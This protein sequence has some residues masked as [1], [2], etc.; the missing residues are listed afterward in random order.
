MLFV[1][2]LVF[3]LAPPVAD[4]AALVEPVGAL[5]GAAGHIIETAVAV[6]GIVLTFATQHAMGRSWR[7]GVDADERTELVT[8]GAFAIVR[9]PFFAALLP[10]SIG[11][12]LVVPNALALAGLITLFAALEIEVRLVEE[13]NL[14]QTHGDEYR[15]HGRPLPGRHR[16]SQDPEIRHQMSP[17][18]RT[19]VGFLGALARGGFT[20]P[21]LVGAG[22]NDPWPGVTGWI[23]F[24]VLGGIVTRL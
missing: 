24:V 8:R 22:L 12:A 14:L 11:L 23:A 4:I 6:T 21:L 9:N 5:D 3:G 17:A 1:V 20:A 16:I 7:I 15:R 2:A 10:T 19:N 18:L 13:P